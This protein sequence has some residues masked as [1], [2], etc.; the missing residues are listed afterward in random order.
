M[1]VYFSYAVVVQV[2]ANMRNNICAFK[3]YGFA[4]LKLTV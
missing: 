1:L 2:P 3:D 4:H